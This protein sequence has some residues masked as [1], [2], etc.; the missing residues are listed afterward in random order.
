MLLL[1]GGLDSTALASM[2][3][4]ECA[5][6]VDYGQRPAKG[7]ERAARA[8]AE[9]LGIPLDIR[10]VDLSAF[11]HGIMSPMGAALPSARGAP[12]FWPYRNQMLITLA[13]MTYAAEP[14]SEIIIGTVVGDDAHPDGR[15]EFLDA[16]DCVVSQQSGVRVVA[17][18]LGM[19][20]LELVRKAAVPRSVLGWTFSCHTGEWACGSC[21]GCHKH[22]DVIA[23]LDEGEYG[24]SRS[25]RP[26]RGSVE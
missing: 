20:T 13:A 23:C 25:R 9:A 18:A 11:G 7:E 5:L 15:P 12:E 2:L 17:P 8:V 19:T 21:R 16:M 24:D 6:F 26:G 14:L 4:I 1:T 3:K 10:R 22:R